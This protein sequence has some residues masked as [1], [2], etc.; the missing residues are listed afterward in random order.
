M[1]RALHRA[2][3]ALG[4]AL[5]AALVAA[6]VALALVLAVSRGFERERLRA[7]VELGLER[8]LEGVFTEPPTVR[9]G[10]LEGALYPELVLRDVRLERAG[11]APVRLDAVR[12]RLDLRALFGDRRVVIESLRIEGG[13]IALGRNADGRIGLRGLETAP[14]VPNAEERPFAWPHLGVSLELGELVLDACRVRL[15]FASGDAVT[16]LAARADGTLRALVWPEGAAPRWPADA[17]I[18][19]AVGPGVVSGRALE[20]AKLTLRLADS[21]LWLDPSALTSAFGHAE[22]RGETDLEGWLDPARPAFAKLETRFEQLDPGVPLERPA[23]HGDLTG[24]LELEAWLPPGAALAATV[25][26]G[27]LVLE[28]SQLGALRIAGAHVDGRLEEGRWELANGKLDANAARIRLTGRGDGERIDALVA[29]LDATDLALLAETAVALG[30]PEPGL[31]GAARLRAS[32]QGPLVAPTGEVTLAATQLAVSGVALGALRADARL[33]PDGRVRVA[34]LTLDGPSLVASADGPVEL[35]RTGGGVTIDR[36]RLRARGLESV[37]AR[38]RIEAGAARD[39][40]VSLSGLDLAAPPP[41]LRDALDPRLGGTLSAEI[42]A[43]GALPAP[44]LA[45]SAEWRAPRWRDARFDV[46]TATFDARPPEAVLHARVSGRGRELATLELRTP[47]D[48][49]FAAGAVLARDGTRIVG[50]ANDLDASVVRAL[51]PEAPTGLDGRADVTLELRGASPRPLVSGELKVRD[52]FLDVPVVGARFGPLAGRAVLAGDAVRI[53]DVRLASAHG[54]AATLAGQIALDGFTP[55]G[56]DLHLDVRG[57][58]LRREPD[59][60]GRL[61]GAVTVDGPLDALSARGKLVLSEARL[62]FTQQRN[63]LFK[64]IRVRQLANAP[65]G[66]IREEAP[67]IP[68]LL[69]GAAIDVRLEIADDARI[70]GQGANVALEGRLDAR[71]RPFEETQVLGRIEST[72]GSYRLYGK[73]FTIDRGRVVFSGRHALDPD[74]DVSATHRVR[75]VNIHAVLSGTVSKPVLHLES[76]PPYPENDLLALLLF[77]R[78]TEELAQSQAGALSVF[79][80]QTAG[81]AALDTLGSAVGPALPIENFTVSATDTGTGA[82][83]GLGHYVTQDVYVQYDQDVTGSGGSRVRLDWKLTRRWSIETRVS[84]DGN[85]S[86]D[87]IWTY[88]Y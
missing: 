20:G 27:R 32:L 28:R 37:T 72:R 10:A 68:P 23:L 22:L 33:L 76:D 56:A 35:R 57:F 1:R 54:G 29:E 16:Q 11:E 24:Q 18:G 69:D 9:V 67:A 3:A 14:P 2:L 74:L 7:V 50:R 78:T 85:S 41:L 70:E 53:E 88:D 42:V 15:D 87:L 60:A 77:G 38:G 48:A 6:V 55:V 44:A 66:S 45:G 82:S 73:L 47:W 40:R 75:D 49:S 19:L 65:A 51:W 46:L 30:A 4:F 84:T 21:Y 13:E 81:A 59:F 71:K 83:V 26:S 52:A 25:A 36:L 17:A 58:E 64:E 34:P 80:A 39:L 5:N 63:P 12:A 8:A 31:A 43:N 86:A 62:K 79:V 61:D